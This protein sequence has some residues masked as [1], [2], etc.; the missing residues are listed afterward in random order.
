MMTQQ[1]SLND[2]QPV[3]ERKQFDLVANLPGLLRLLGTTALLIAMYS[4]LVKGWQ[5]GNDVFRYLLMLGHTG[6]LAA[7]GLASG[8]WLNE[9]KGARLLLTLAL[10]SVPANFA[11]LGAF[12]YSQAG[13]IAPNVYPNYVAWTVDSMGTALITTAAA[14]VL[15]IPVT[16]FGFSVLARSMSRKLSLLFFFS[17]AVLL[18]PIRDPQLIGVV[19][20]LLAGIN[21]LVSRKVSHQQIAAKTQEGMTALGLQFLPLAVLMGRSLWLYSVDMFLLSVLTVTAFF[22]LRQASMYF[23]V[24]S[25]SRNLLDNAALIPAFMITPLLSTTLYESMFIANALAIP[26][27]SLVSAYMIYDISLRRETDGGGYRR[28][29]AGLIVICLLS[30]LMLYTGLLAALACVA[31]GIAL[32]VTGYKMQQRTI[33]GNGL[34]L[35]VVGIAQQLY[36]LVHHFDLGSWASLAVLGIVSIIIASTIESQGNRIKPIFEKWKNSYKAWER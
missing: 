14:A 36:E 10:V 3:A 4:F 6:V 27:A 5:S 16:L 31:L 28:I 34:V 25:K 24:N 12:I 26:L 15:I 9:S 20:L 22:V 21:V 11:I 32:L 18:L 33:F 17:N 7:I 35:F 13:I 2:Q 8:H 1:P 29:A 23:E 30:N 19:V